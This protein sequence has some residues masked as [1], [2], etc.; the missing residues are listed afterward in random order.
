[1][2][3]VRLAMISA[4]KS[5]VFKLTRASALLGNLAVRQ[6]CHRPL[7]S[8]QRISTVNVRT[9]SGVSSQHITEDE[10]KVYMTKACVKRLGEIMEKGE[11][12]R[13]R[14]EGGGCSGF[15]YKFVVDA[16]TNEDD[17][18]F[19]QDGVGVVVD[20]DS[21]EFV[22]GATVDFSQELIRATFQVLKNPRA[23][24]GCSCGSSFSV[25]I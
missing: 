6:R 3:L 4:T 5:K 2:S 25:K 22:K 19:E 13:I 21:M 18:V 12:L 10:D 23:E 8:P 14:V 17:R 9:F 1:M 15:Q 24:H 20:Q 7:Y 16:N 11:Y